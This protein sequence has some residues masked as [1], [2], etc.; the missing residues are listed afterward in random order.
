MPPSARPYRGATPSDGWRNVPRLGAVASAV[1]VQADFNNWQH[2][3][4]HY[5]VRKRLL[6]RGSRRLRSRTQYN[7][8]ITKA[9]TAFLTH[10]DPSN[11]SFETR[12]GPNLIAPSDTPHPDASW[13]TPSFPEVEISR[14]AQISGMRVSS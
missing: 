14:R 2:G 8:L 5:S 4:P 11:R 10:V 3:S 7:H 1:Q 9:A 6:E 13:A 12:G